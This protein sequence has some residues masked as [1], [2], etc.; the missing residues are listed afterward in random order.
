MTFWLT[1]K[2]YPYIDFSISKGNKLTKVHLKQQQF[3]FNK[4]VVDTLW[5]IPLFALQK[6]NTNSFAIRLMTEKELE[7]DVENNE[8]TN[9]VKLNKGRAGF[10]RVHYDKASLETI[11]R[12]EQ[13]LSIEDKLGLL[14]DSFAFSKAGI[15]SYS[16]TFDMINRFNSEED[17]EIW[18]TILENI[19][20]LFF[21][22]FLF[23]FSFSF[24]LFLFSFSFSFL[25]FPFLFLFFF[26]FLSIKNHFFLKIIFLKFYFVYGKEKI[27]IQL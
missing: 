9:F 25:F 13:F 4:D 15:S 6:N 2:G 22:L 16:E 8:F 20:I 24:F 26:S 21:F 17:P 12:S 18:K 7:F 10:Y 3:T 23:S 19:C 14:L 27:Y 11:F 5:P 1:H